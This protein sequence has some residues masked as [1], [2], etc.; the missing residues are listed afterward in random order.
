MDKD[1]LESLTCDKCREVV[2]EYDL[3]WI[4]AEGF[5]PLEDEVVNPD[6][7]K[8]YEAVCHNCYGDIIT[9]KEMA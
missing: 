3:I 8:K 2:S 9:L 5:T 1:E 7:F 4:N 6:A